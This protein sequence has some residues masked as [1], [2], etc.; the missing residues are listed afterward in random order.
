MKYTFITCLSLL[1]LLSCQDKEKKAEIKE[2]FVLSNKMLQTT[3]TA[4]VTLQP[5]R[6]ELN[7]YGKI[8]TDNNKTIEVFPVVGGSV[9]KV[10]VQ[11]GD[12]VNKGQLLATIRSTEVADFEKQLD[13]AKNDVIVSKNNLKVAQELFEGKLN[14]DR[15]VIE[16]KSNYDKAKSQLQ[17]IQ[18]TYKIYNIKS[19]AIY[20][21]R[22]PLSGFII[23]KN[24]NEN[25]LLRDDRSDNIFD[26]AEINDV[27]AIANVTESEINE[28][29]LGENAAVSTLSYPDKIFSGKVDKIFNIIDPDTKAMKVLIKLNN[30]DYVL[31]PEMRASIKISYVEKDKEMLS[32]PA[33]AVIF[34]K[35][36]NFV[37]IYKDR[38]NI[39][40]RQVEVFRQVGDTAYISSGISAG[41][42]VMTHNQLLVYGAL[43]D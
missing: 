7:Y 8:T 2:T 30:P 14:S 21:V 41:E 26:I 13:D 5:L 29:K 12:Y 34:D 6:N 28:I 15:D 20:E 43:N 10:Y 32:V 23:Q 39:E 19:G 18:E 35:S 9:A 31:K 27:W 36:K 37:I 1:A 38:N 17:R 22:S 16:A 4:P 40:T 25:M 42:K 33:S 11:L 3:K 24:I